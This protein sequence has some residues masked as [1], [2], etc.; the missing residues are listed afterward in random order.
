MSDMCCNGVE[1]LQKSLESFDDFSL[2]FFI[3]KEINIVIQVFKTL[4]KLGEHKLKVKDNLFSY[5]KYLF[6]QKRSKN[7]NLST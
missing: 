1:I 5:F 3:L 6:T 7:Q 2:R 4:E